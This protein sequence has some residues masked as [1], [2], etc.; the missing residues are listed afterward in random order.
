MNESE[1]THYIH[2]YVCFLVIIFATSDVCVY[3]GQAHWNNERQDYLH[4]QALLSHLHLVSIVISLCCCV[5]FTI[6]EA[7]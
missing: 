5:W 4:V 2:A 3:V 6:T 7:L 1:F